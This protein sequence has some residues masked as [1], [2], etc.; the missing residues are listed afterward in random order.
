MENTNPTGTGASE[1]AN[2]AAGASELDALHQQLGQA[3]AAVVEMRDT[4]LR[5]RAELENQ[6]RRLQRDLDQARKFANERLLSDLL[7]VC[8]GL[9]RGAAVESAD[10]AAMRAGLDLTYKALLKVVEGNGLKPVV[11]TGQAFNPELHQAVSMI[12]S[13][14]HASGTVVNTLQTGYVLNDRLLRPAMV[15]VAN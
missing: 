13:P 7:P 6:R 5:E 3:E 11:P 8:D 4:L 9:E 10:V 12:D 1:S 14:G 15:V 2:D